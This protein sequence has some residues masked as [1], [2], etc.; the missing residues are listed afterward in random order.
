MYNLTNSYTTEETQ[1]L[2]FWVGVGQPWGRVLILSF[3]S[4]SQD[5]EFISLFQGP[6]SLIKLKLESQAELLMWFFPLHHFVF[7]I[8]C[9]ISTCKMLSQ[10]G[11]W[12]TVKLKHK[13]RESK[14]ETSVESQA[15]EQALRATGRAEAEYVG[16][17]LDN[18][19]WTIICLPANWWMGSGLL[20][21]AGTLVW[22]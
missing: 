6:E 2:H 7:S 15:L 18:S 5:W 14:G 3:G 20:P 1:G 12:C 16:L 10:N 11:C 9:N 22:A 13:K 17:E 4:I 8:K 19:P 21:V